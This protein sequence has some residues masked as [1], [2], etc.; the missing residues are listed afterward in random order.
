MNDNL[1]LSDK[2]AQLIHHFES[3]KLK[4]YI[5]PAGKLTVGWGTTG[6]W[7][8]RPIALGLTITQEEA[9][10]RFMADM[11]KFEAYVKKLIKVPLTQQQF[12]ALVSLAYNVGPVALTPATSTLARK[13]NA[14]DYAG[15]AEQLTRWNKMHKDGKG[16][17][18]PCEG[19]T[20]RRLA[21]Q[22]LFNT[23]ELK[24]QF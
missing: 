11:L 9:D 14:G 4:A 8:G 21:E 5:C 13:L 17:L 24:F 12:D 15:A 16:P 10:T 20:R 7:N 22:Y 18:V 1:H 23:G 2:G 3:C 6:M 19:L